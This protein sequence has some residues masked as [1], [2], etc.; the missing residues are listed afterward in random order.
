MAPSNP[1]FSLSTVTPGASA[2][3]PDPEPETQRARA[4][5]RAQREPGPDQE[6]EPVCR[7]PLEL[8]IY[9]MSTRLAGRPS[10]EVGLGR[11]SLVPLAG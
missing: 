1:P 10:R 3:K 6:P 8:P 7:C 2:Y 5:A 9:R 11:V 4:R